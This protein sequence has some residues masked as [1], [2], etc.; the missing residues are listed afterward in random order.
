MKSIKIKI[1]NISKKKFLVL[2]AVLIFN[3]S[4]FTQTKTTDYKLSKKQT[5]QLLEY[6]QDSV[7]GTSVNKAYKELLKGKKSHPLI[8]ACID[9][10]VDINQEDL[11][12]HIWTNFHPLFNN[13]PSVGILSI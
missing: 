10:G 3:L 6:Q 4:A 5:W 9:E 1:M 7:Y 11:Q 13:I 8:V 12:G 2:I